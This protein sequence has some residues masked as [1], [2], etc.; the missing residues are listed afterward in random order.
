MK[1][2]IQLAAQY[3]S[4]ISSSWE[5]KINVANWRATVLLRWRSWSPQ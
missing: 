4:E 5:D 3:M 2:F 1:G